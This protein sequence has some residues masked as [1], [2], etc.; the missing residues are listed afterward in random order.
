MNG[1]DEV[2]VK[3]ECTVVNG[4]KSWR[5][6]LHILLEVWSITVDGKDFVGVTLE[7]S[8]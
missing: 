5:T 3:V 8:Y 4:K 2:E 7:D 6:A 1:Q